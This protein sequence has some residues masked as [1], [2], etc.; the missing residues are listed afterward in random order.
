MRW[1]TSRAWRVWAALLLLGLGAGCGSGLQPVRGKVTYPDGT[2]VT[3]G[4][5]VFESTEA[6]KAVT[7]RGQ[8]QP[9]GSY[10]LGTHRPGDGAPPGKYRVLVAPKN[11]PNAVDK[12]QRPPA[13]DPRFAAFNT[14][15]LVFEV[16]SGANEF[17]I[18]VTRPKK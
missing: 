2:P 5:V 1:K 11:D 16:K 4:T 10:E 17:P 14:S 3:E 9:D 8:I 12:P 7:A 13:F 18:Q 6:E 15:E